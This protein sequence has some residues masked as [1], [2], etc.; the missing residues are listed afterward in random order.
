MKKQDHNLIF[1]SICIFLLAIGILEICHIY[2]V[3]QKELTN[4][5]QLLLFQAINKE[6]ENTLNKYFLYNTT[7]RKSSD[8]IVIE[9][10]VGKKIFRKPLNADSIT[11]IENQKWRIQYVLSNINPNHIFTLDSI[12]KNSFPFSVQTCI[13]STRIAWNGDTIINR[14]NILSKNAINLKP[15]IFEWNKIPETR[16]EIQGSIE[17]PPFYILEQTLQNH[18][19]I[20][21]ITFILFF[22]I[23]RGYIFYI[24]KQ[25][26]QLSIKPLPPSP[27]EYIQ[28]TEN[29]L[30][31]KTSGEIK[32]N[33]K[34][35]HLTTT[36]LRF[37]TTLL[38][39]P[40]HC[41]SYVE[42]STIVLKRPKRQK[43]DTDNILHTEQEVYYVDH[44]DINA[45]H[46][47]VKYL[48]DK[49]VDLPIEIQHIKPDKYQLLI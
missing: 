24:N 8:S 13:S 2:I 12:F 42:I 36:S 20:I 15:T 39:A 23:I 44:S 5:T 30:F 43:M 10:N 25:G 29:I 9:T 19:V 46:Q 45:I 32:Y 6:E 21:L 33:D 37:F 49:V 41:L 14:T 31:S 22:I 26:K 16:I 3:T 35:I 18:I 28:L 1:I 40:E 47:A 4:Y 27:I 17:Y 48:R 7:N 38:D 34:T 11:P